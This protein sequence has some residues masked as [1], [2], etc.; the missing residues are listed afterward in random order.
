[1]KNETPER[2]TLV[3]P[4]SQ[5]Q[6]RALEPA[7]SP[8]SSCTFHACEEPGHRSLVLNLN[9]PWCSSCGPFHHHRLLYGEDAEKQAN[10][11]LKCLFMQRGYF[12]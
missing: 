6:S 9:F 11:L 8:A 1:M 4:S 5:M 7:P 10:P 3:F 2:H 12:T